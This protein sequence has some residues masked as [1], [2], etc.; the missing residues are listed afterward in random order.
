V[1]RYRPIEVGTASPLWFLPSLI[2]PVAARSLPTPPPRGSTVAPGFPGCQTT[3]PPKSWCQNGLR[4]CYPRSSNAWTERRGGRLPL[5]PPA[6]E[7]SLPRL[8][9]GPGSGAALPRPIRPR[10]GRRGGGGREGAPARA[11]D[12]RRGTVVLSPQGN[13]QVDPCT[14]RAGSSKLF[15]SGECVSGGSTIVNSMSEGMTTARAIHTWW[16]EAAGAA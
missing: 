15:A 14:H 3:A 8:P 10:P 7:P 5:A 4:L 11:A 1:I 2:D 9:V 12:V 16:T 6:P 13:L